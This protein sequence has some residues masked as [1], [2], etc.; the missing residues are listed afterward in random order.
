MDQV[1]SAS[2]SL[3]VPLLFAA[4]GGL[5]AERAGVVN[6][7]MEGAML[8]GALTAAI[9]GSVAGAWPVAAAASVASGLVVGALLGFIMVVCR[10]DQIV[11]GLIFNLFALGVTS[12]VYGLVTRSGPDLITAPDAPSSSMILTVIAVILVPV[13][14]LMFR[15]SSMGIRLR[16]AGESFEGARAVGIRVMRTRVIALMLSCGLCAVGGAYLVLSVTHIFVNNMTAGRGYIALAAI[17]L[18]GWRPVGVFL[19]CAMF[20][21]A[22]A[23]QIRAQAAGSEIPSELST[24]FP[25]LITLVAIAIVGAR[26]RAPAEETRPLPPKP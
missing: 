16:A 17:I 7:A 3:A 25:Y 1:I 11:V 12:Y 18:G 19:A 14:L 4:L 10:G 13:T 2:V 5:L 24:A 21:I 9:A 15:H 23:L 22:D 26:F 6:I 8:I 20:G